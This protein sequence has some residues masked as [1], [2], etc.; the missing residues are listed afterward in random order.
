MSLTKQRPPIIDEV[1]KLLLVWINQKQ[2]DG[3]SVSEAIICADARTLH[4]DL[5]K[6]GPGSSTD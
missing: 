2:L 4:A 1:E 5:L 3:G 6:D